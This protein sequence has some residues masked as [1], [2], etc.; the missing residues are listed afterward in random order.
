[1]MTSLLFFHRIGIL[2]GILT[3]LSNSMA[4]TFS[5]QFNS[6]SQKKLDVNRIIVGA[7]NFRTVK[8]NGS[9]IPY[10][11][12]PVLEAVGLMTVGCTATHLGQGLVISAGHC[13]NAE[14]VKYKQG[15]EGIQVLWG[16]REG[17]NPTSTS[18]CRQVLVLEDTKIRDYALFKVDNPPRMALP[19]KLDGPVPLSSRVTI[20]SHPFTLP[21]VWSGICEIR[22]VFRSDIPLGLI[23][24]Q[25]DTNPGSSGAAIIDVNTLEVAGIHNGGISDGVSGMNYGTY[26]AATYIPKI[27][28]RAGYLPLS[29]INAN[30][31]IPR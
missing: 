2:V 22:K 30:S 29:R 23:H 5:N 9:N 12:L 1:M 4:Q 17:K 15:C 7:D 16:V 18:N 3:V 21:L 14:K 19:I 24:H 20:F 26:I 13:F 8:A 11:F 25:C 10:K 31:L 6:S 27:L 28:S